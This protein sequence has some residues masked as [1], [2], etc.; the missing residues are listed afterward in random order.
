MQLVDQNGERSE[1]DIT[2]LDIAEIERAIEDTA[3]ITGLPVLMV[4]IDP[5]SNYWGGIKENSNAE[6]RSVLKPLQHLAEKTETAFVLIQHT[7]KADKEYAQQ[8]VLGSTG[9]WQHAV[10]SGAYLSTLMTRANAFLLR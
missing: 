5:I 4:V 9:M 6:V 2:L 8:R 1:I 10:A 3:N 7:G